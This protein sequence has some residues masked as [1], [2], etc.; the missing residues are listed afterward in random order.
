MQGGS[1][2]SHAASRTDL[3]VRLLQTWEVEASSKAI[4]VT[5]TIH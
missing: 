2:W 4:L 3:H 1:F 5:L